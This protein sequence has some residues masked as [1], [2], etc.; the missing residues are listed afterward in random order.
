[1]AG[2][3]YFRHSGLVSSI[4]QSAILYSRRQNRPALQLHYL[5]SLAILPDGE[6]D[7]GTFEFE[8]RQLK[9]WCVEAKSL[10]KDAGQV[11]PTQNGR[12]RRLT[13]QV[14]GVAT[15]GIS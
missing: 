15:S 12:G 8:I 4:L 10:P 1:M 14:Y 3:A 2:L 11:I 5:T 7:V 13:C 6:K 9:T